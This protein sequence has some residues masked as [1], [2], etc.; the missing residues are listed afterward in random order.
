M[1]DSMMRLLRRG[2]LLRRLAPPPQAQVPPELA[3]A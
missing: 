3:A 2:M 1:S